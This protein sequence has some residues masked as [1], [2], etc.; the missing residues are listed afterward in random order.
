M[1]WTTLWMCFWR[2]GRLYSSLLKNLKEPNFSRDYEFGIFLR[3][4][5][6]VFHQEKRVLQDTILRINTKVQEKHE[7]KTTTRNNKR[8]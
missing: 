8:R 4:A 3:C 6:H 7:R 1:I 2:R 5:N